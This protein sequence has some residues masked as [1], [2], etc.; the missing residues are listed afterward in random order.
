MNLY[1]KFMKIL[2]RRLQNKKNSRS[3]QHI[4][5]LSQL[6]FKNELNP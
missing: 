3:Y 2:S 5:N 4:K 1:L 6:I